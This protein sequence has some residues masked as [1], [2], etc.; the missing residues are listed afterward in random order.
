MSA[1][2]RCRARSVY[3]VNGLIN[4]CG[5]IV[6]EGQGRRPA[7]STS[8]P[9][10]SPTAS[11]ARRRWASNSPSS[12]AGSCPTSIFYPTGGGTGL[13]GMWKAFDELEAIGLI[14]TKR[15]RMVAVQAEGCAPIVRAFEAGDE[16]A[17]RWENA[18][19]I[20][21]RHPRAAGG[22]RLPDPARGARERRLRDR[23]ERRR[24]HRR[25]STRWRARTAC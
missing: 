24:D 11:R 25:A 23:G 10:R 13:I 12:S 7:G 9:S 1:R 8:R 20:A 17:P 15:P 6:G 2:S 21:V 19:T 16:H 4:D 14:G 22:R 5:K 3:R 18:H